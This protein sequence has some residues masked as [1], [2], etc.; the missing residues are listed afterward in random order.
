MLRRV[1]IPVP[2]LFLFVL[3]STA[4]RTSIAA[5]PQNA[6]MNAPSCQTLG[7]DNT[8]TIA[9]GAAV[10]ASDGRLS[11]STS[12]NLTIVATTSANSAVV[13]GTYDSWCGTPPVNGL[14]ASI[15]AAS[16]SVSVK[17]VVQALGSPLGNQI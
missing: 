13:A 9:V 6:C 5:T 10:A 1:S 3:S 17:T 14:P 7:L 8:S 2:F 16:S 15:P 4:L 11:A 12:G